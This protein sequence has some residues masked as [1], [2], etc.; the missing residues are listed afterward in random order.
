M[1]VY[2]GAETKFH[3]FLTLI[4]YGDKWSASHFSHFTPDGSLF[5]IQQI[6]GWV[7]PKAS[8]DVVATK[9][10]K[11]NLTRKQTSFLKP[12]TSLTSVLL[13]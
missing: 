4:L 3:A 10:K 6:G 2:W 7:D 12:V 11:K 13:Q 5:D 9:K 8:L 1:M